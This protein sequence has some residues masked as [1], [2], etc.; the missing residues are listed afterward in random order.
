MYFYCE[1]CESFVEESEL[2]RSMFSEGV[3]PYCGVDEFLDAATCEVC[4]DPIPIDD[5]LCGVCAENIK[6]TWESAVQG[7]AVMNQVK[8]ENMEQFVL[9]WIER[10]VC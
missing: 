8:Y 1:N 6:N 10:E 3:C 4:G 5:K 2:D 7:L 9:D